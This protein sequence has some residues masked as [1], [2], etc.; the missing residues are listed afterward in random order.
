V[1]LSL[2]RRAQRGPILNNFQAVLDYLRA[3]QGH[4][5]REVLRALFC[6]SDYR[7]IADEVVGIGSVNACPGFPR[8]IAASA[9]QFEAV[10]V[11]LVHNHP[12]GSVKPSR[13]DVAFTRR[14]SE[15]LRAIDVVLADHFIVCSD[16]HASL[17]MM[18]Y[19]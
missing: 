19:L 12:S 6:S 10:A 16:A 14:V 13:E 3:T 15:A 7:L 4:S 18:G 8:N 2:R 17:R 1:T 5:R 11:I 9:L